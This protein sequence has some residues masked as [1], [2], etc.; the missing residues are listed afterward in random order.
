MRSPL[1]ILP[2]NEMRGAFT[3]YCFF[4]LKSFYIYFFIL[5]P[6]WWL[7]GLMHSNLQGQLALDLMVDRIPLGTVDNNNSFSESERNE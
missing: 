7:S 5:D 1:V 6:A 2:R 4:L 3:K